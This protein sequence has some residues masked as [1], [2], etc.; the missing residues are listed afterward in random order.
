MLI[1]IK[2]EYD[3]ICE[4]ISIIAAVRVAQ[5]I[6]TQPAIVRELNNRKYPD[7]EDYANQIMALIK[8]GKFATKL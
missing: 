2:T 6:I 1:N 5:V 8:K 7:P 3:K 4:M